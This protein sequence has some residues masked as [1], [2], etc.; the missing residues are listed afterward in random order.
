MEHLYKFLAEFI[1]SRHESVVKADQFSLVS[2]RFDNVADNRIQMRQHLFV[3][4]VVVDNFLE[5]RLFVFLD[6]TFERIGVLHQNFKNK[7]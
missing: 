4:N 1:P 3:L 2:I 6:L 7:F 5:N